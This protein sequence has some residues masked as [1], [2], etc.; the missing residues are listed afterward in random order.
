MKYY[1][2]KFTAKY[3]SYSMDKYD[4]NTKNKKEIKAI[5][6]NDGWHVQEIYDIKQQ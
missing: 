1:R 2:C 5:L 6:K 3:G 4:L